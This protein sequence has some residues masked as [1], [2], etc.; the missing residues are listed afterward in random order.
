ML[1]A[2]FALSQVERNSVFDL[3]GSFEA[4]D[5]L[6]RSALDTAGDEY[7]TVWWTG[8]VPDEH[9]AGYAAAIARMYTDVPAG[10]MLIEES[11]WDAERVRARDER[12]IRS[13]VLMGVTLVIHGPSGEVA[14]FNELQIGED[15]TRPT[16]Q[17]G[18]LVM[19]EHRGRRLGTI[20]K[21]LGLRN[22]RDAAPE[23]PCV[24]TFNAEENRYMLDVN[25]AVGFVPAGYAGA[26]EKTLP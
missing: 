3:H 10:D 8:M 23:S 12:L 18:T 22:W 5:R 11:A 6:L 2:G 13:G 25:E 9:A 7:R 4:T 1:R 20:V 26:W 21:C 24:S 14:A 15:R 19:P 17:W 16:A